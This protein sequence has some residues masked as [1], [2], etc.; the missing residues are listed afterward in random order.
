MCGLLETFWDCQQVVPRQNGFHRLAFPVTRGTTQDGLVYLML[1]N[2][3]V[4]NTRITW[5][6]MMVEDYMVAQDGLEET[7]GRCLGFLYADDGMVGS[8][9][10]DWLQH[11][12]KVLIGFFRRYGLAANV[13]KSCTMTCQP[14]VLRAGMLEEAMPLKCTGVG[15]LY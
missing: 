15:D 7:V 3:V 12:M 14:G 1:F 13:A 9:D 11:A 2:M 4:D 8:G 6:D 5:L 10:S